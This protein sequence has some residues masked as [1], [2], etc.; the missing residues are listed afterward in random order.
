MFDE[1]PEKEHEGGEEE[2]PTEHEH[3]EELA[4]QEEEGGHEERIET[5]TE[6]VLPALSVADIELLMKNSEIWDNLLNGKISVE[7]AKKMFQELA[8]RYNTSD[9]KKKKKVAKKPKKAKQQK[10]TEEE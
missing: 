10:T 5:E 3:E 1:E 6:E 2:E 9:R 7:E 4:P 8:S